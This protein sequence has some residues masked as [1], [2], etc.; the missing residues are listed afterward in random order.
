MLIEKSAGAI[1]F[2]REKG[3]IYYLLLNYLAFGKIEKSY[4]GFSKGH[5]EK[6]EKEIETA[7]R[8]IK[9]ETGIRD[10]QLIRG[11]KEKER[12]FFKFKGKNILKFVTYYL[13]ETKTKEVKLS[14]EH[15]GYKWLSYE[16]ALK[17]LTFEGAREILKK[18]N[19]FLRKYATTQ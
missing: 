15:I 19:R 18:A 2:R 10:F 8:E 4:W 13:I 7:K 1:V 12:Y 9:E 3:K 6:G 5:I 11:F 16:K 14:F 17:Q